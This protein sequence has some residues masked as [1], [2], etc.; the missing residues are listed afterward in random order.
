M[1]AKTLLEKA[2]LLLGDDVEIKGLMRKSGRL[3][4][5]SGTDSSDVLGFDCI[6]N[7][8]N[9]CYEFYVAN[10]P[11]IGM[12]SPMPIMCPLGIEMFEDYKID[13]KE[14]IKIFQAGNYGDHFVSISLCKP[15]VYPQATEPYWYFVSNL[16]VNVVI[17]ANTG[18]VIAPK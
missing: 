1:S 3:K 13:Y 10:P 18:E 5:N 12:T 6:V 8:E 11:F 2:S 14:A 4:Q 9:A 15:L 17:G 7:Y 16:G